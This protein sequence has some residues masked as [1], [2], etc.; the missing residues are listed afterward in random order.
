[1]FQSLLGAFGV[2]WPKSFSGAPFD[3]DPSAGQ[4][5]ATGSL[6]NLPALLALAAVTV[7]AYRGIRVSL[8]VNFL[9]LVLKLS[10]LAIVIGVGLAHTNPA[11]WTP[12]APFGY[13]GLNIKSLLGGQSALAATGMLAGATTVFFAFGGFEMLSVYSNECRSPR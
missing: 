11:N 6:L 13:G 4:F 9:L 1:Y 12:F 2:S 5:A 3:L 10:V 8:R 7:I